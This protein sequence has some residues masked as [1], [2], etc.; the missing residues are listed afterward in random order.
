MTPGTQAKLFL[1]ISGALL[2]PIPEAM[3]AQSLGEIA[4]Q[5]QKE[6]E[7]REK[8]GEVPVRVFT[9]DD[10]ARMPPLAIVESSRPP[11]TPET[12]RYKPSQ[13]SGTSP[14][15]TPP[16]ASAAYPGKAEESVKTKEYWQARFKAARAALAYAKEEQTVVEDELRLLQIQQAR[17]LNPDRSRELNNKI[18][19]ST[20]ELESKRAATAK[21]QAA[22]DEIEKEFEKSGAPQDWIQHENPSD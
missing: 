3:P 19:A 17:E 8:K 22:L 9:N 18:N 11:S 4:R 2:L 16:K 15:G 5:Y 12:S 21:A 10:I 6:R 14:A 1:L 13:P 7:A 20:I